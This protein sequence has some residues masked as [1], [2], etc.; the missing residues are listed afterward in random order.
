MMGFITFT[1]SLLL[2]A[3]WILPFLRA[4]VN[5]LRVDFGYSL[6]SALT[7]IFPAQGTILAWGIIL[8]LLVA[9]TYEWSVAR[10]SDFRRFY[11]T[12]CLSIAAAPLLG[13]RTE[14]QYLAV[15]V[16]PL[17]LIFAIVHDR[18]RSIN[19]FLT[20]LLMAFV[21]LIP[22]ALSLLPLSFKGELVFLFLPLFTVIGLYWIRWW[23]LRPPR[24]WSDLV[25]R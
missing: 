19:N 14:T 13:F 11:W 4:V 17:A 2:Y 24:I 8:L 25:P 1:V 12:A 23:A 18:W 15:L 20:L 6:R 9:L 21:W 10:D 3:N 7:A 5:N 16:V 22:W